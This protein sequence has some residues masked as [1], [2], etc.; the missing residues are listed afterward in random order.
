MS[1]VRR[2]ILHSRYLFVTTNLL[3][4]HRPFSAAERHIVIELLAG[5]RERA[6]FYLCGYCLMPDHLHAIVFPLEETTVSEV[7]KAFKLA[8]YQKLKAHG[9]RWQPFWQ[10]RFHDHALRTHGEFDDALEYMHMNPVRR[11]LV[12][13]PLTW[14][15]SS[16]RWFA[17]GKGPLAMDEIRTPSGRKTLI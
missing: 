15:W 7:M 9:S 5:L 11:G 14:C 13:D 2:P 4:H 16:A 8:V 3:R 6:A 1:R 17:D 12:E 10:S